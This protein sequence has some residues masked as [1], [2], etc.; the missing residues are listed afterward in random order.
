MLSELALGP[1]NEG[2]NV[3]FFNRLDFYD[4]DEERDGCPNKRCDPLDKGKGRARPGDSDPPRYHVVWPILVADEKPVAHAREGR[5][6]QQTG[7]HGGTG[8]FSWHRYTPGQ[9]A[10]VLDLR[11]GV[12]QIG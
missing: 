8:R 1:E 9:E 10:A 6:F 11:C 3:D 4:M 7:G 2:R 12:V 5:P